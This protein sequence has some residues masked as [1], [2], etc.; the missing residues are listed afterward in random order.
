[1]MPSNFCYI[2]NRHLKIYFSSQNPSIM[3][4]LVIALSALLIFSITV[5]GQAISMTVDGG[6]QGKFRGDNQQQNQDR[7]GVLATTMEV[8]TATDAASGMV[9]GRRQHQPFIV[10]KLA[11][12]S[13]PQFLQALISNELLKKVTVEF[14]GINQ[15]GEQMTTYVI[16]L[17]NVRVAGLKQYAATPENVSVKSGMMSTALFDEIKLVYQ[18]ITV[19]SLTGKTMA[20]DDA[21][22][23]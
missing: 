11:G 10:K 5:T 12:A 3:K 2:V 13:S 23:L 16:T 17:E 8:S 14:T 4:L 1:M 9:R 21:S 15:N 18:K 22:R 6:Q 20:T 7:M 19:E